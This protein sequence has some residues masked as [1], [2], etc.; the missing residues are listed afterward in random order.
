MRLVAYTRPTEIERAESPSA[1]YAFGTGVAL[2]LG[3]GPLLPG[4]SYLLGQTGFGWTFSL[5]NMAAGCAVG[6][7]PIGGVSQ[8]KVATSE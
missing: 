3:L 7:V 1:Y 5:T 6:L 8:T 4:Y 2:P